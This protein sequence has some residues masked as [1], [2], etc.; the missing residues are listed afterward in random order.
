MHAQ[1]AIH[2]AFEQL[3]EWLLGGFF[4]RG[5]EHDE[6]HVRIHAAVAGR[7]QEWSIHGLGERQ[8]GC[9]PPDVATSRETGGVRQQVA[10]GDPVLVFT[11]ECGQVT[12]HRRIQLQLAVLHQQHHGGR[13]RNHLAE[14]GDV[15]HGPAGVHRLRLPARAADAAQEHACVPSPNG[16]HGTGKNPLLHRLFHNVFSTRE[17]G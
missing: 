2:S 17:W 8:V 3:G 16:E 5:P 12:L 7:P 10:H 11:P 14:R 13:G 15:V 6:A 4:G 9:R 1:R